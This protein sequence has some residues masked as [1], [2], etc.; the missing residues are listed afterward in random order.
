M[1]LWF[2][3]K[4]TPSLNFSCRVKRILH[5]EETEYQ[6]LAIFDTEQFG[7]M[8]VLD[9]AIQ[10]TEKDEFIYHEMITHVPLN[11]HK[12]PRQVVVIGGGDG[13]AV[14]EILKHRSVE[15][16]V[17]VEIDRRVVETSRDYL[18]TIKHIKQN[19]NTYDIIII[20][21]TDPV[22]P[23]QGL[24][25][26][27]FYHSVYESLKEDG[28]MVA[29][30][31]TPFYNKELIAVTM[32]NIKSYFPIARMYLAFIPT[33]PSGCWSFTIGSKTYSPLDIDTTRIQKIE[34]R[35]YSPEIHK[36]AFS[37]P[38]FVKDFIE[39]K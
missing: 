21:S 11:I 26:G 14:K 10:T 12:H 18:P 29:Q 2:T 37:L 36:A 17:L 27:E 5:T 6:K 1:E 35:Y 33:Y 38:R 30:T 24:F 19:K 9:G 34:T 31:E 28:V 25:S 32:K 23:A 3:E 8:L 4:Q 20:D 22:G 15:K 39:D 7:R 13:G 16:V